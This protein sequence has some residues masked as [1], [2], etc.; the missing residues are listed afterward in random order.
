MLN[1]LLTIVANDYRRE[2]L[3]SLLE[4]ER[5]RKTE[6]LLPDDIA[7]DGANR[8]AQ[9]AELHHCHLPMLAEGDLIEWHRDDNWITTGSRFDDIK[10]LLELL[11]EHD[12]ELP[13]RVRC[14]NR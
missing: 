1:D 11:A 3:I 14:V 13:Y 7:V 9:V 5:D 6:A 8:D 12:E 2:L 10:P 4:R